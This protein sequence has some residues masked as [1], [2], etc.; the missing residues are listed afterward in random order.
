MSQDIALYAAKEVWDQALQPGQAN[1]LQALCDFWPEGIASVLDVG[2]GDG[3]LSSRLAEF[4]SSARFV[5]LDSSA[6]ALS[7][8]PF[9]SV[10]GDATALPF[11]DGAFDLVM[12]TDMLEHLPDAQENAAWQELFRVAA[13][14][15]MVAVPFREDLQEAQT[16][17][18]ACGH[19]YHVNWHQRSYDIPDLHRRLPA[20]WCIHATVLSGE[21]WSQMLPPDIHARRAWLGETAGWELSVC[22]ECSANGY[23]SAPAQP[24]PA[25]LAQSLAALIYP[26]MRQQRWLR[27]HSE[28][29]VVFRREGSPVQ[30]PTL[31]APQVHGQQASCMDAL[32][33]PTSENL[34]PYCQVAHCI[35]PGSQL[36]LQ[37][38]LY[39][40]NPVLEVHRKPGV[41]GPLHLLLEDAGGV[42]L[43]G[44]VL[45]APYDYAH[46][47]LPRLPVPGY[48]GILGTCADDVFASLR[49]GDGPEILWL[50]PAS[51]QTPAYW[52]DHTLSPLLWVQ[53]STPLWLDPQTLVDQPTHML[54]APG[55]VISRMEACF[56]LAAQQMTPQHNLAAVRVQ[57]SATEQAALIGQRNALVTV[58]NLRQERDALTASAQQLTTE[59]DALLVQRGVLTQERDALTASAQELTAERDTLLG[60]RDALM[61]ERDDL[62]IQRD[63]LSDCLREMTGRIEH[64]SGAWLRHALGSLIHRKNNIKEN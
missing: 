31:E 49:L 37:F 59:R 18:P 21:P 40:V 13:D 7:R 50:Q 47:S 39:S 3:K 19:V 6:E 46:V 57:I 12:T 48:Y 60:Q 36:R 20:G 34:V 4:A 63:T 64:R 42:L 35:N 44:I 10:E 54:L 8:L 41:Q 28:I 23:A 15:V 56:H 27:S 24:L 58:R 22:P 26:A 53:V 43:D 9:A 11:A 30:V 1:L 5:G 17:C 14:T 55:D 32:H 2:C 62:R 61:E 33:Q 29:L 45:D 16:R 25:L 38:P 52:Q 51:P